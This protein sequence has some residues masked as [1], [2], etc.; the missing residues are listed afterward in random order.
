MLLQFTVGNYLSFRDSMTL[1]LTASTRLTEF[2]D[3]NVSS[4]PGFPIL[5]TAALYGANASGKS[6]LLKAMVF[7]KNMVLNSSKETQAR[8][9][10]RAV[11]FKFSTECDAKPSFFEMV[12]LHEY[13]RYRYGFEVDSERVRAEWLFSGAANKETEHF[14]RD[15]QKIAISDFSEGSGLVLRTRDNALFVSVAAQFNGLLSTVIIEW[16][17]RLSSTSGFDNL[18]TRT[19]TKSMLKQ[20]DLKL[21]VMQFLRAA[22]LGIDDVEL[23]E[24]APVARV[25]A[26]PEPLRAAYLEAL[27]PAPVRTLHKKYNANRE[28]VSKE[29]LSLE[30]DESEGT[31][32]IFSLAGPLIDV[33]DSGKTLLIDELDSRL[34]PLIT[35][36][37]IEL[38]ASLSNPRAQLLFATHDTNLLTSTPFRR[39]QIWFTEKDSFGA[40]SLYSLAEFKIDGKGI[41]K[42]A[43][44][45]K[46]YIQG[47]YGA[48][49]FINIEA[50]MTRDA[51]TLGS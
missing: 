43:S 49:P 47:K 6:N 40:S 1:D 4:E 18:T 23:G 32:K 11:R 19:Q 41:R 20:P 8:E 46:D 38:F 45:G 21:R 51:E 17:N 33:L 13:V 10:I 39:D 35:R 30:E 16:F 34:H 2:R 28:F 44:F 7:M 24:R 25:E 36:F 26:I 9:K 5:K 22:D 3:T 50:L 29:I 31:K 48:I 42:D 12:F 15:G 14:T 37:I 27:F